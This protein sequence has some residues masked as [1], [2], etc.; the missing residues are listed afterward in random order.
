MRRVFIVHGWNMSPEEPMLKWLREELQKKGIEVIAPS[1]PNPEVPKIET[2]V[3][4]LA[5][6]V[7]TLDQDTYFVGHSVGVQT[8]LRV[9]AEAHDGTKIGGIISIAGWFS[10]LILDDEEDREIAEPWLQTPI[11]FEKVQAMTHNIVA[12]FSDNDEFVPL[13]ETREQFEKNLGAQIIEEHAQGH[14][15]AGSGV[16]KLP[17][18]LAALEEMMGV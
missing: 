18:A 13:Q 2:W 12:I 14:F 5:G 17:S 11:D 9:L 16:T 4:L 8:I 6:L 10:D 7:G 15:T 1:M 3:P